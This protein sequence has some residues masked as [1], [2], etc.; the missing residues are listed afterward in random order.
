M[1]ESRER[2]AAIFFAPVGL[3]VG[4]AFLW[5]SRPDPP[6]CTTLDNGMRACMPILV[7]GPHVWLYGAFGVV[8][9]LLA[10]GLAF[11]LAS[12]HRARSG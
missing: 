7:E 9:A 12:A 11:A 8:G 4:I 5:L 10:G 2:S 3:L 1:S 6:A